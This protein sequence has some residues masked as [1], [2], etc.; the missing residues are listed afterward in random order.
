MNNSIPIW[1]VASLGKEVVLRRDFVGTCETYRAG[2][3]GRL[4]SIQAPID[5][6]QSLH[7]TV[8]LDPNDISYEENFAFEDIKPVAGEIGS[9]DMQNGLLHF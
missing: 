1:I 7:V 3:R 4:V 6:W 2:C 8:A 9:F 5:G